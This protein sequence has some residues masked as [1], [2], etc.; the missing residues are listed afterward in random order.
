MAVRG[1]FQIVYGIEAAADLSTHQFK[2]VYLTSGQVNV[3]AA[4]QGDGFDVIGVLQ[5]KLGDA[6]GKVAEVLLAGFTK[7]ISGEAIAVGDNLMTEG[8][9]TAA[10]AGRV[11]VATR[12]GTTEA[13]EAIIGRALQAA[14][15]AGEVIE[16][17]IFC[18]PTVAANRTG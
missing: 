2:C 7:V 9:D 12:N 4:A 3:P 16:A 17:F 5:D 15:G 10:N 13:S 11:K 18:A 6:Q 1:E 8:S 14:S